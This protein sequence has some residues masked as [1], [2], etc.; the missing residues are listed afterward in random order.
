[1]RET[2][3][4]ST[5]PSALQPLN[6]SDL[7]KAFLVFDDASRQLAG[8]YHD[9]QQQVGRLSAELVAANAGLR[10]QL[11]EKQALAARLTELLAALPAAVL[12]LDN[13]GLVTQ[14]N[15]AAAAF[16]GE[17]LAGLP[18]PRI[19]AERLQPGHAPHEWL[20]VRDRRCLAL[21]SR[22]LA[23]AAGRIVVAT[24]IT[25]R[26]AME[27]A[28]AR[29]ER[30]AAMGAMSAS[31]AHQLRTPLAAALLYASQLAQP[32]FPQAERAHFS[33]E[34]VARLR[35]LETFIQGTLA[36]VRG[37]AEWQ[38]DVDLVR[39]IA[40]AR[41]MI[42][43]Q[44]ARAGV[45]FDTVVAVAHLPLRASREALLSMLLNLLDNALRACAAGGHVQLSLQRS[46]E[47]ALLCVSDDGCGMPPQ[48]RTRL[49]EPYFTTRSDGHGLGLA[50]VRS[51]VAAHGGDIAVDSVEGRGSSFTL[52]LPLV[53][54]P[55]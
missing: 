45:R 33:A 11:A 53:F 12:V 25:E 2:A 44:M 31:L 28:L 5:L 52:T 40:D 15:A 47:E 18:W 38:E 36:F 10:T 51:V 46:G 54:T 16:F 20:T 48:T 4:P 9:L 43:P 19:V 27:Q 32:E 42:A 21:S 41:D 7:Q 1:M 50:F 6:A 8:S 29:S 30:L 49:F 3:P 13:A 24:D 34:V 26:R 17:P 22:E 39:V 35:E 55:Q 23:D 14:T 37:H